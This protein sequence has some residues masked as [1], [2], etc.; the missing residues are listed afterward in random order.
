M[1]L[2]IG[3]RRRSWWPLA[4]I[5]AI[6][7]LVGLTAWQR[8]WVPE[9][10]TALLP[11]ARPQTEPGIADEGAPTATIAEARAAPVE[12]RVSAY[13]ADLYLTG[14]E[15]GDDGLAWSQSASRTAVLSYLVKEGDTLWS[16]AA[17]YEIDVDTL[18]WSNPDL[19]RNPDLLPVGMELV[20]LPV[21]GVYHIAGEGDSVE[22]LA[23]R[24]G[25][26]EAD[27]INYPLNQLRS[28]YTLHPGQKIIVPHGRKDVT[29]PPP[30]PS[31]GYPLAWPL[32]GTITQGYEAR[33]RGLDIGAP[34]GAKVFA[35]DAGTV[36]HAAWARTG[37]GFTVII[38]HGGERQ[39][40][41][42]HLKGA[43]VTPGQ[44]VARG[45]AIGKVGSTGNST[46]PH[47]HFEVREGK[48]RLDPVAFLPPGGPQ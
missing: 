35:A 9:E 15:T 37:Y 13:T 25:V 24:Y 32:V 14:A 42:S 44:Q 7:A 33:H 26:S 2:H 10:I 27:I 21:N 41:Y 1:G 17:E 48:Q 3:P 31:A 40:L 46:G 19:E 34:Y 39:T 8:H 36:V 11:G 38:D 12:P 16:I 43:L 18:R 23:E 22:A 45:E 30:A 5:I 28:P 47:V 4:V 29:L 20:I 6:G